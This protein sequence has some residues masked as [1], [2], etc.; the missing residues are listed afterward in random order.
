MR[1]SGLGK[2]YQDGEIIIRQGDVGDNMFIIQEGQ[3]E[4]VIEQDGQEVR[5]AVEG[6]GQP[7]GE[8]AIFEHQA[9]SATVRALGQ[10]RILTVDKKN[11][12]RRIHEDPSLAYYMMRTMSRRVREL[13]AEMAR[14]ERQQPG[15]DAI[16][17]NLPAS[18]DYPIPSPTRVGATVCRP[19]VVLGRG[20]LSTTSP[21]I[22]CDVD[23]PMA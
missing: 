18:T 10:A 5:L 12:V 11:L 8:M 6:A 7:I 23:V 20:L 2:L 21:Y 17:V 16:P 13:S 22:R 3:V 15:I 1:T 19:P 4:V 9:R 14:L